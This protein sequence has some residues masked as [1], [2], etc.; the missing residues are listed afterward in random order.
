MTTRAE[1]TGVIAPGVGRIA[2]TKAQVWAALGEVRDP[3]LDEPIT[4]LGF[5]ASHQVSTD[6]SARVRLRLPTYFCAPNFAFLMVADAFDA[7][8]GVPGV[9]HTEVVLDDH[10]ASEEINQGVAAGDGFVQS[11]SGLAES[12]LHQLR[13]DFLRKAVMAGTDRVCRPLLSDGADAAELANVTLGDV[14]ASAELTRLRARRA[15]L[16]LP[17][18]DDDPLVI[19][20]STGTAVA[21]ADVQRHLHRARLTRVSAE[22]NGAVC[23]GLLRERYPEVS[24]DLRGARSSAAG[25][26]PRSIEPVS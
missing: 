24:V 1:L 9:H 25:E 26:P 2:A 12:E 8:R 4:E 23:R 5:V 13:A 7:V 18:G 21:A 10:F 19:D 11:F 6:G 14:P 3:E 17:A 16:R 22:A 20:P 15:E